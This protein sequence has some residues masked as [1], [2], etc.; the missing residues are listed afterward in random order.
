MKNAAAALE[1]YRRTLELSPRGFFTAHVAVDALQREQRGELP[2]GFYFA[3]S[4]LEFMPDAQRRQVIPQLVEKFPRFAPAWLEFAKLAET[5]QERLKRIEAGL[6]AQPD[7]DTRGM[8]RLNQALT[9]RQLGQNAAA[10]S[11]IKELAG[12][13]RS[14]IAVEAWA[15]SLLAKKRQ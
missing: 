5:P 14:T 1:D 4:M 9:L 12:D 3:Y 7:A 11:I 8:L 13:P 6:A 2:P 15:K 10:E